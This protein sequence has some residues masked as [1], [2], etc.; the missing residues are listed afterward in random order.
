MR[1]RRPQRCQRCAGRLDAQPIGKV[2]IDD[3]KASGS[4][5]RIIPLAKRQGR[6]RTPNRE[7]PPQR[8]AAL[9][10]ITEEK[11]DDTASREAGI[12]SRAN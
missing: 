6:A 7:I 12:S 1:A 9:F 5:R 8:L 3:E 10:A 11:N 2:E 4:A